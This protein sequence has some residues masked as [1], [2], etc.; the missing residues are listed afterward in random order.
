MAQALGVRFLGD[1]GRELGRGGGELARLAAIDLS[2]RD[3]RLAGIELDVA[4]NWHNVLYGEGGVARVFGPQKGASP[5]T[6]AALEQALERYAEVIG[7]DLGVDARTMP[8]GGASGGLGAG[9]HALLGATLHPRFRIVMRYLELDSL[10]EDADLVLSAEGGIDYQTP[11]GKVPAEVARRAGRYDLPVVVLA[12]TI[13]RD[14]RVNLEH[15]IAAYESIMDAPHT[16]KEAVADAERLLEGRLETTG[17][18]AFSA[19]TGDAIASDRDN[20]ERIRERTEQT[21]RNAWIVAAFATLSLILLLAAYLSSDLFRPLKQLGAALG[22]AARGDFGTRLDTERR[23]EFGAVNRAFNTLGVATQ[24][25]GRGSERTS[26][27]GPAPQASAAPS[28]DG[29]EG[30]DAQTSRR[31]RH[32]LV[33]RRRGR[34]SPTSTGWRAP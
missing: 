21:R 33:G 32:Q 3:P 10:L 24:Q 19:A 8:G 14:A 29:A 2:G 11:Q 23:N 26:R 5:E 4:C 12:G 17:F 22:R 1:D 6:V 20:R 27:S 7:R 34:C 18:S 30:G 13:G 25:R 28:A 16:L 31:T 9:L 15:K